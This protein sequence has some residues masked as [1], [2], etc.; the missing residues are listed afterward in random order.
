MR[1]SHFALIALV[2]T[3]AFYAQSVCRGDETTTA[4]TAGP[5]APAI[6]NEQAADEA[7]TKQPAKSMAGTEVY[8]HMLPSTVWLKLDYMENGQPW[9]RYGTGWVYDIDRRLVVTNE[10]VVHNYDTM[11]AFLPQEVDGELQNDP[12]W[13]KSSGTKYV[14]KVIDRSTKLDLALLQLDALPDNAV[15]LKLADKSPLPGERLFVIGGK[16]AGSEG[17]WIMGTGE[18]RQ[19]YRRTHALG[20]L[21]RIV[22]TQ[23]PTNGGN[24]GGAVVN[25]RCEVVAVVE[26]EMLKAT[27]VRM[28]I[29]VNEV[30]DYLAQCDPLVEPA[31]A[32]DFESRAARRQDELRYDQAAS[33]YSAALK[34][35]PKR[36]SAM[37]NRGWVYYWKEDYETAKADF[38]A[39]LKIDPEE[40]EAYSG[41]GTCIRELGDYKAAIKDLTEAIRRDGTIAGDYE[42][43][44]KCY[45][46]LEEHEKA[47]KDR[48][49]A[50]TLEPENV[51]YLL[52]HGQTLRALKR[53][54]EAQKDM[55]KAISLNPQRSDSFYE[56]GHVYYAQEMYPQARMFFDMAV[57]RDSRWPQYF[58]MRGLSSAAMA[59]YDQAIADYNQA[60]QLAPEKPLYRWN[61][62][63][64]YW[65]S[66]RVPE[67]GQAYSEYIRLQPDDPAGYE[68]RAEVYDYLQRPDLA[69]QDR[70]HAKKLKRAN[71]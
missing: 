49:Q 56:L 2:V 31:T 29:D 36:T 54:S 66:D 64:A 33:D 53:Y 71:K 25:D 22:E 26:G 42:R 20:H 8:Q 65:N 28:F 57:Q 10:H 68:E 47:L 61:L 39:V 3:N 55:E 4:T 45:A 5:E 40:R 24:S 41:R 9:E 35:E 70:A 48:T 37:V 27:L 63:I 34:L 32:E 62:A 69:E 23:L 14:A 52:S 58:D 19:V 1:L 51:D 60:I 21:A 17:L 59:Q 6:E 38:E 13:Y 67:S 7:S 43:R 18:V 46:A 11:D 12:N 44:A 30:R 16:P 50:I 15:A